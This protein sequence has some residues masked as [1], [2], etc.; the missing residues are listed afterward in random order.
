MASL[1]SVVLPVYNGEK[2]VSRAIESVLKQ[3][4]KD[5]ELILVNDCSTDNTQQV[6]QY[7]QEQDKRIKVINNTENLKLP[8]SLNR[9]FL[10]AKGDYLTWTSD[11]NAYRS[12]ALSEMAAYLDSH[13]DVDLVYCDFD[14]INMDGSYRQTIITMDPEQM[15][16]ENA[17]GACFLYRKSL[18]DTIGNY[19]PELFLAEDYEYW[20]RAYLNGNLFHLSKVLY[21]YGW[22]DKSLTVTKGQQVRHKTYE[23]KNKHFEALLSECYTQEEKNRF[24]DTMLSHLGDYNENKKVRKSYYRIDKEYKKYDRKRLAKNKTFRIWLGRILQQRN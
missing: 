14:I 19:D 8:K 16:Y 20:I 23:A 9:G 15:K 6:L 12:T 11:D 13:A 5:I 1:I 17:V 3:D 22:H 18:A 4:Y 24:F 21:D 7:Y 2:R 10:E